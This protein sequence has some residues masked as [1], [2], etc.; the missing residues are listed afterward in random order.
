MC[1][2]LWTRLDQTRQTWVPSLVAL[3]KDAG[4]VDDDVLPV[5]DEVDDLAL[6]SRQ[7]M[8]SL[9][10]T[11]LMTSLQKS[12]YVSQ[13]FTSTRDESGQA[14]GAVDEADNLTLAL[15]ETDVVYLAL[16]EEEECVCGPK[17]HEH[18]RIT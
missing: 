14:E 13:R 7:E 11:R 17:L 15:D 4:A 8:T 2:S 1:S 12:A 5:L 9:W 10:T 18:S 3:A 6:A 16:D